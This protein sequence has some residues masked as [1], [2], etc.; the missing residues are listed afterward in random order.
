MYDD[1]SLDYDR[2]V[3]WPERL[4]A[5][6]PFILEWIG[7]RSDAS[8]SPY[9]LDVACGTGVHA[10]ALARRGCRVVGT[11]A[12]AGMI[13]RAR[14]NAGRGVDVQ[15]KVAGFGEL[16]AR[17][18]CGFDALLCL[19]NSLPHVAAPADLTTTLVDFAACLRSGGRL[20]IQNRNF[21]A[22]LAQRDRWM[23]PQSH[24]D[25][26]QEWLFVRFYD[27]EPD[28]AL[29][30]NVVTLRRGAQESWSQRVATTRLWP[31]RH[32]DLVTAVRAAG[33]VDV[34]CWG[35]MQGNRF[36]QAQSGNLI[37]T[38]RLGQRF[39]EIQKGAR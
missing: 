12:S 27:F 8:S 17:V 6:M 16:H 15:F 32:K 9:V 38:A 20:L 13:A 25:Q 1:F 4:A 35:D 28:G 18:G 2:F 10:V 11:D 22:V 34:D 14:A 39:R 19:G 5:E 3:D 24:R 23:A 29:T 36:D 37:V 21:D 30:F 33:F 26:D 7:A 31:L